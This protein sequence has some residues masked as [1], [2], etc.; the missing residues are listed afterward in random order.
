MQFSHFPGVLEHCFNSV[1]AQSFLV[2]LCYAEAAEVMWV[3]TPKKKILHAIGISA[4][5]PTAGL[6]EV[7]IKEERKEKVASSSM[8]WAR[9]IK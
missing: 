1:V 9:E 5:P 7:K 6:L 4:Q 8:G 2:E 3:H